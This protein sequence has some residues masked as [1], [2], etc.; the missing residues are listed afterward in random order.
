MKKFAIFLPL[1]AG[2]AAAPAFAQDLGVSFRVEARTGYDEVRADLTVQNSVFSDDFGVSGILYGVEAGA[3]AHVFNRVVLGAYG[4][5]EGSR[6]DRCREDIFSQR[7]ASRRDIVCLD[8]GR[9]IYGGLRAGF[10]VQDSGLLYV[11]GGL[12]RGKFEGSYNVSVAGAGQRTGQIFSGRDTVSGYHFG[13]GFELDVTRNVYIKGEYVQHR[14]KDTFTDS[15]N[16]TP[17][18]NPLSTTDR[19]DPKRHQLVFGVGFR[20]GGRREVEV[21][22]PPPPPM[23]E[24][25]PPPPATQT[26]ADGSV[27]LATDICPAPA[28]YVPP[29]PPEAAP[30][31]G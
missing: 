30:E 24:A 13:G 10:S 9:N 17:T 8:A 3:D 1:L 20:F 4:G 28:P 27:I 16:L 22:A 11:K 25:A 26:C 12:S 19:F 2:F 21:I 5:I 7:S 18:A 31:R 6:A 14:Y 29:A 15:L 23:V